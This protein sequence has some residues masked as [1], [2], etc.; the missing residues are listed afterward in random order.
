[1]RF[2]RAEIEGAYFALADAQ[3]TKAVIAQKFRTSDPKAIDATYN[4]FKKITQLDFEPS[5]IGA[6]NVFA[7]LNAVGIDVGNKNLE[8]HVDRQ[9]INNLMKEGFFV[10]MRRKYN[11]Q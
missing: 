9:I 6:E 4:D 2:V 7:Q 1:M 10:S 3:R 8:D 11:V 5:A